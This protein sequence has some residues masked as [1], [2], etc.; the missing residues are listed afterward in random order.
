[1]KQLYRVSGRCPFGGRPCR[2]SSIAIT[3]EKLINAS[4]AITRVTS[5]PPLRAPPASHRGRRRRF[6]TPVD[7]LQRLVDQLDVQ[8]VA[9]DHRRSAAVRSS[10]RPIELQPSTVRGVV[11]SASRREWSALV[12]AGDRRSSPPACGA[13]VGTVVT[14]RVTSLDRCRACQC[15]YCDADPN[16][17]PIRRPLAQLVDMRARRPQCHRHSSP[18]GMPLPAAAIPGAHWP[19]LVPSAATTAIA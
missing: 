8:P 3:P 5:C 11:P 12:E 2:S 7:H 14:G 1:M 9:L 15:G 4:V 17:G 10:P 13:P 18:R 16:S 19:A 6:A